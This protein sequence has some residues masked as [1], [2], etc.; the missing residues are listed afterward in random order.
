MQATL[1]YSDIPPL[2]EKIDYALVLGGEAHFMPSRAKAAAELYHRGICK[3]FFTS[4]GVLRDTAHG[5]LTEAAALKEEMIALGVPSKLIIEE[6]AATTTVENMTLSERMVRDMLGEGRKSV[7]IVTSRFH[8]RR[9]VL[10]AES[11]IKDADI[12]GAAGEYPSDSPEEFENSPI[13]SECIKKECRLLYRFAG[14]GLIEDF[15]I[16]D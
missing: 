11:F 15:V 9:S 5:M 10:L 1:A 12:F 6:K 8:L 14:E 2:P 4:G 13:M 16:L 3:L 7:A